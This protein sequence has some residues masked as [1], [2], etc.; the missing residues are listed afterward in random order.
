[1][2]HKKLVM[3]APA[4][5]EEFDKKTGVRYLRAEFLKAEACDLIITPIPGS[6]PIEYEYSCENVTCDG[7]CELRKRTLPD[8]TTTYRCVCVTPEG[9]KAS[10]R[11]RG[12]TPKKRAATKSKGRKPAGKQ[13]RKS[14]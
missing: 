2:K 8:G 12:K 7:E 10:A 4:W 5:R 14:K 1:M 13:K 11:S 3:V 9:K 6:D